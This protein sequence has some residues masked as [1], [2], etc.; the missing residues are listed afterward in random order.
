MNIY[1]PTK[2]ELD[3]AYR[4]F[5][6]EVEKNWKAFKKLEFNHPITESYI[7]THKQKGEKNVRI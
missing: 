3:E 5:K 2:K 4:R 1:G 7:Y 6:K